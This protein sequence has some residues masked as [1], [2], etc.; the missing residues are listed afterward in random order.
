VAFFDA[1]GTKQWSWA[2]QG[3]GHEAIRVRRAGANIIVALYNPI[4]TGVALYALD[5]ATGTIAWQGNVDLLSIGHS[6]YSNVVTL[7][8]SG[9]NVLLVGHESSQEYVET[10]DSATGKRMASIVRGR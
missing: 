6:K 8:D 4:A 2:T 1:T 3:Y 9:T 7:D 5:A 10:F